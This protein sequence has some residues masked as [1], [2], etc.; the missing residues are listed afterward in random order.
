MFYDEDMTEPV[1]ETALGRLYSGDC[2]DVIAEIQESSVDLVFADPPFNLNK[3]YG[4]GIRDSLA[5]EIASERTGYVVLQSPTI[6][7]ACL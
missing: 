3:N 2:V 7:A 4:E 6:V 1:F 5:D